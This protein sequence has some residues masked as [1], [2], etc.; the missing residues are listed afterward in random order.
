MKKI[1]SLFLVVVSVCSSLCFPVFG[2]SNKRPLDSTTIEEDFKSSNLDIEQYL[3]NEAHR[4]VHHIVTAREYGY[5]ENGAYSLYV[6]VYVSPSELIDYSGTEY[7]DTVITLATSFDDDGNPVSFDDYRPTL[8]DYTDDGI[9]HKF[10]IDLSASGK[11]KYEDGR[12]YYISS[13]TMKPVDNSLDGSGSVDV[14]EKTISMK[15]INRAFYFTGREGTNL[16]LDGAQDKVIDL[17]VYP[18]IYRTVSNEN[19]EKYYQH[20]IF[21]VYFS[22]PNVYLDKYATLRGIS[23]SYFEAMW[24]AMVT[25][26]KQHDGKIYT[27]LEAMED[28]DF[29]GSYNSDYDG[30]Y[31]D[32]RSVVYE[33]MAPVLYNCSYYINGEKSY[34]GIK[35][36]KFVNLFKVQDYTSEDWFISGKDVA[37]F[38]E[39]AENA[40]NYGWNYVT[41]TVDEKFNLGSYFSGGENDFEKFLRGIFGNDRFNRPETVLENEPRI[42]KIDESFFEG[43]DISLSAWCDTSLVHENEAADFKAYYEQSK[44]NNETVYL[45]RFAIRDYYAA[46]AVVEKHNWTDPM[47][48]H[49]VYAQGTGFQDFRVISLTFRKGANDFLVLVNNDPQDI[50]SGVTPPVER[51]PII[52]LPDINIDIPDFSGAFQKIG[53]ILGVIALLVVILIVSKP[54]GALLGLIPKRKEREKDRVEIVVKTENAHSRKEK[55]KK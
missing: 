6:Y 27:E 37:G 35:L 21:S 32:F 16:A 40:Q 36:D 9:F 18:T 55:R 52:P 45:L 5:T 29:S 14:W 39:T 11:E 3:D 33:P 10:R 31:V 47:D 43:Y 51:D 8:I 19:G 49:A 30:I 20:D 48:V 22:I 46:P 7:F 12:L 17:D 4:N 26:G 34:S 15:D 25:D 1:I 50:V 41:T 42:V 38:L 13:L 2:A 54:I 53:I 23:Y 44:A 24:N 28:K